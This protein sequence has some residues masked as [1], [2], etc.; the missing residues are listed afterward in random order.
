MYFSF[1]LT[2][3]CIYIYYVN[4]RKEKRYSNIRK[5]IYPFKE[6]DVINSVTRI[7]T[8][9]FVLGFVSS[10]KSKKRTMFGCCN[11]FNISASSL[12]RARSCLSNCAKSYSI[13]KMSFNKKSN[14]LSYL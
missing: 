6:P 13:H 8:F 9:L 11:F 5:I 7:I 10:Q 4:G 1:V 14:L 12:K 3:I 2:Y